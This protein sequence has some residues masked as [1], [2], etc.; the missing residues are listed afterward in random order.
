MGR[1]RYCKARPHIWLVL[2]ELHWL[3]VV[4]R[5]QYKVAVITHKVLSTRQSQC[6]ADI[7]TE[8]KL[9]RQLRSSSH[10]KLAA[11]STN[12][13]LGER[14]FICSAAPVW[15]DLPTELKQIC[16]HRFLRKS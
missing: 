11:R 2:K 12:N 5:V 15:N 1:V 7:V 4:Q 13:Q 3:P 6:L 14:T 8:Y 10:Y 16:D 9:S